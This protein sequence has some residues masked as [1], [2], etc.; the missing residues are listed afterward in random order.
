MTDIIL[1][2]KVAEPQV[3]VIS[4]L[5]AKEYTS[6]E[7]IKD[8]LIKQITNTVK[9]QESV[10]YMFGNGGANFIEVGFGNVLTGLMHRTD[11][12]IRLVNINSAES[13]KNFSL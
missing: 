4:N 11:G 6:T 10:V 8:L 2:A 7:E 1:N 13:L 12:E 3:K 9:W 5:T